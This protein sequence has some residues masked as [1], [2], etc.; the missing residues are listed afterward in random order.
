[1]EYEIKRGSVYWVSV[2][3]SIGAEE[4]T[5]R[6][7]VILSGTN[8]NSK[9]GTVIV[10][11]T[12]SSGVASATRVQAMVAGRKTIVICDQ[13]RTIDKSRLTSYVGFVSEADMRRVSAAVS[14]ALCLPVA[15]G[16]GTETKAKEDEIQKLRIELDLA[17][18]MYDKVLGMLVSYKI[19]SDLREYSEDYDEYDGDDEDENFD[20]EIEDEVEEVVEEVVRG[21]INLNT[22]SAKEIMAAL[23]VGATAAYSITGY[24]KKNGNFVALEEV[25]DVKY[26]PKN[27]LEKHSEY[28][29]I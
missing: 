11:Y 21:K 7:A 13:I 17:K 24:R 22:A 20:D 5:G 8:N 23:G 2:D 4:R 12:T 29:E 28:I 26:I 9:S 25:M 6:P 18:A 3:G 1:M 19:Q 14:V 16:S 27:F 10:A 15:V